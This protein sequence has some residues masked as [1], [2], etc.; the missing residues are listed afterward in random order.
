MTRTVM[1]LAVALVVAGCMSNVTQTRISK[2]PDGSVVIQSGKDVTF[3]ELIWIDKDGVRV[4]VR[5]YSSNVNADVVR[6]QDERERA[7]RADAIESVRAGIA[8][9]ARAAV[10]AIVPVAP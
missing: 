4:E 1:L 7:L 5:G 10:K 6:A 2:R 8:L 3:K 9:G